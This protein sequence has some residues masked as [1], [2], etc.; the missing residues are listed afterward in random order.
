MTRS[1]NVFKILN[2]NTNV[3]NVNLLG[4]YDFYYF[5]NLDIKF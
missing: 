2:R 3:L 4:G 1:A 5:M